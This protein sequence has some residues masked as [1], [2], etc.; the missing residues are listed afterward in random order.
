MKKLRNAGIVILTTFLVLLFAASAMANGW[1]T[2]FHE[3]EMT[4]EI[5]W[6]ALSPVTGPTKTMGFPYDDV[7][8]RIGIGK[9][10]DSEW[11]YV[12]FNHS[13]N[14]TNTDIADGHDIINTRIRWDEDEIENTRL[15]QRWGAK[16]IHFANATHIISK[17]ENHH[18]L[19]LELDWYGEG[20]VYFD[21]SLAGSKEAIA[22]IR[23]EFE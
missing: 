20:S 8:A 6:Y 18:N 14:L 12:F 17:I 7:T 19:L 4:G 15:T 11:V 10:E 9:N 23:S 1:V 2:N 22:D 13:P 21:F 16:S 3:D 5:S